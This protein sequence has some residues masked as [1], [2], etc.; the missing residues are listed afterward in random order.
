MAES[1]P[2]EILKHYKDIHL[3]MD[4][5]FVNGVAFFLATSRDIGFIHCQAVLSKHN[6]RV[7]DALRTIVSD[8][9]HRG[10]RVCTAFGDNAFE[11]LKGWMKS[12]LNIV[13]D[14]CDT[15]SHVPRAENAIKFVKEQVRCARSE[16]P[17]KKFPK[18]VTIKLVKR[19][20]VL[21][22][23]FARKTGV[24]PVLSP[25]QI[26]LGRHF[27]LPLCKYGELVLA[28]D[29]ESSNDTNVSRAFF[30]LYVKPNDNGTGHKVFKLQT[31]KVVSTPKCVLKPM[32]QDIINVVNKM[33]EEEGVMDGIQ[34]LDVHG[35]ATILDLYPADEGDDDS[36]VS[37]DD[38]TLPDDD[39]KA[40][41]ED[42]NLEDDVLSPDDL[43][44]LEGNDEINDDNNIGTPDPP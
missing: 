17:F 6:Q 7:Q 43:D 30:A 23:S 37:D 28:Y 11:P 10:F 26:V 12:E 36:G 31:K 39:S 25:Q 14:T 24:H 33:G 5:M 20:V 22:N 4:L 15:N 38:Y 21:I 32:T 35:K 1:V 2:D 3:D 34:F 44:L 8:Y 40:D 42:K 41:R 19:M 29:T 16:M 9:Q 13:L 27:Q 18:R